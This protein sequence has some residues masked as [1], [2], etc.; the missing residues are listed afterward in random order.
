MFSEKIIY[1]LNNPLHAKEM[2]INGRKRAKK[3]FNPERMSKE[4]YSLLSD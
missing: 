1:L 4:Y 3:L 2:G